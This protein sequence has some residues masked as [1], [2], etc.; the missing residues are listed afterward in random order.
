MAAFRDG[1]AL[2]ERLSAMAARVAEAL[3]DGRKLLVAGNGG[4]AADAQHIAGEFTSRL[5]YDRRPLAALALTT[6]T[7]GLTAIGNDYG[8]QEVFARQIRG[9]GRPGDVF[10]GIST[11]G[12]SPNILRALDAAREGGLVTLGFCGASAADMAGCDLLF[13]APSA[14]TPVIQ[15]VHITAAHI[16]CA[17]VERTLC[18]R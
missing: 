6:D 11:S 4:S 14:W 3:Q 7:S 2:R 9:L 13:E 18:P 15:Q 16:L 5:M 12:R 8:F 1:T 10:L 17:L